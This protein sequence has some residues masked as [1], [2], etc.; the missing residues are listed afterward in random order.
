MWL[1]QDYKLTGQR[2]WKCSNGGCYQKF[3]VASGTVLHGRKMS[4]VD[5]LGVVVILINGAKGISAL[6]LSCGLDCQHKPAFVLCHKLREAVASE[7]PGL[8]LRAR[9]KL[10]APAAAAISVRPTTRRAA[11]TVV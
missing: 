7:I 10:M 4:F 2:R 6:Q 11:K 1:P 9:L 3:S 5:L 8:S